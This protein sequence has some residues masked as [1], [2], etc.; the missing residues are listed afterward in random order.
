MTSPFPT[1]MVT[2]LITAQWSSLENLNTRKRVLIEHPLKLYVSKSSEGNRVFI[3][4]LEKIPQQIDPPEFKAL[5]TIITE[6]DNH[7]EVIFELQ[8]GDY[9]DVFDSFLFDLVTQSAQH[10]RMTA[11]AV[12]VNRILR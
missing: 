11:C 3:I 1:D 5:K 12:I 9:S 7:Y 8:N 4:D 10:D 2:D 6:I